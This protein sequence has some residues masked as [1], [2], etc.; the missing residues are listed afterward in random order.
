MI[1]FD[2]VSEWHDSKMSSHLATGVHGIP[3][4]LRGPVVVTKFYRK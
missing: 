2:Y 3:A 1:Y 4:L